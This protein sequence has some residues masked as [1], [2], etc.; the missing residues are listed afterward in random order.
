MLFHHL[1]NT[2][3][4]EHVTAAPFLCMPQT[5]LRFLKQPS[6][7]ACGG[8]FLIYTHKRCTSAKCT[9]P[10]QMEPPRAGICHLQGDSLTLESRELHAQLWHLF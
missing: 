9:S 8:V 7:V 2:P 6:S 3:M 1:I 4:E 10:S 5:G